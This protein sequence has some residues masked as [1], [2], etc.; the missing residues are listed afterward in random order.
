MNHTSWRPLS[1]SRTHPTA[2]TPIVTAVLDGG[3]AG[4][5]SHRQRTALRN[6][7]PGH[8]ILRVTQGRLKFD[9][10]RQALQWL[11]NLWLERCGHSPKPQRPVAAAAVSL[12]RVQAVRVRDHDPTH[13]ARTYC[14]RGPRELL[15]YPTD[16]EARPQGSGSMPSSTTRPTGGS[17]N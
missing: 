10:P 7:S 17:Y 8:P 3:L 2:S 14:D 11:W 1:A 16:S 6:R 5:K 13:R 12:V 4:F 9:Y 15:R